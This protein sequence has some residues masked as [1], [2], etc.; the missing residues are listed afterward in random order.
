MAIQPR[1][2]T[3]E[4]LDYPFAIDGSG[5]AA[6][7]LEDDHVRDMIEQVLFTAP[8]ERVMLPEFG[9]GL[10]KLTFE[11]NAA[12]LAAA[13]ELLVRGSLQ[14]WLNYVIDVSSVRVSAEEEQLVVD[15]EYVRLVDESAVSVQ[16]V[17][18]GAPG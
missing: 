3:P 7:T 16:I 4:Y 10:L 8:G 13:T 1:Y 11:P 12:L 14:R 5:R 18:P 17:A 15:V 9:C 6:R 2:P